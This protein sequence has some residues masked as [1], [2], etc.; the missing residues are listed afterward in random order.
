MKPFFTSI[1]RTLTLSIMGMATS[2]PLLAVPLNNPALPS[3]ARAAILA[4]TLE[5]FRG[6]DLV[7]KDGPMAKVGPDLILTFHEHRDFLARGGLARFKQRFKPSNPLIRTRDDT[8]VVDIVASGNV[9]TLKVELQALGMQDAA[10][11]GRYISGR[12]PIDQLDKVAALSTLRFA[13]P[14]YAMTRAGSVTSQGNAAM[15]AGVARSLYGFDG[16]GVTVGTLS[17]SYNCKGGAAADVASGDLPTGIAV[18]QELTPCTSGTDEGRAMMQIVHDVAPGASQKFHSAFN[19]TAAFA[20]GIIDLATAGADVINDDVI[21]FAEPMFQDGPIAQAVDTVKG[22]GVAYFSSA[23]NNAKHSYEATYNNSGQT[24]FRSGSVRH[25]FNTTS[26]TDALQSITIPDT[27]TVTLVLQW[28]DPFFSVSGGPG[29]ATDM[30]LILYSSSGTAIQGGIVNNIGGDPIEILQ[31]TNTSGAAQTY[32]I[33][34]EHVAG[35]FPGI[36]KYVYFGNMTI[37]E[38]ATNSGSSYG[39]PIAAGARA[40]G[41]ARYSKTPEFGQT[42]P[43]LEGFS[44]SGGITILFD[45]SGNPVNEQRLKPEIVAPDGGDNTFFGS[46][47]EGNGS[48]NFFGTS[49]AAPHAAGVAAL[50]KGLDPAL[51]PDALYNALQNTAIDMKAAGPDFDSGYGLIQADLA[52]ASLVPDDDLDGIANNSDNCPTVANPLQENNDLDAQ[53]DACDL[54]DDNDGLTDTDEAFYN[55]DPFVADTDGDNLTDGAEVHMYLTDPLL[56]DTDGDGLNDDTEVLTY[57]TDP[58]SSNSGDVAPLN[59]P[60]G[61]LNAG[62]LV[63]LTRIVTGVITANAPE[64]V[65][66]DLNNDGLINAADLLLLQQLILAGP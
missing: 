36:I 45:S 24:G 64:D 14:A 34:I 65:L 43:L 46:D 18:L 22:M 28:Q 33:G 61:L 42:P 53:G 35:P 27:A 55:T 50:L 54:D 4:H 52:L 29:A 11:F 41:A 12:L 5:D 19:G 6:K 9:N 30:D 62:D 16:T 26:A 17:D 57:A 31:Y 56:V 48:P 23:G 59:S 2:G 37:N 47:F 39:H 40:V 66:G 21:Y 60:D 3:Q 49:A 32:Q 13:R 7:G 8:V 10:V 63:V 1:A 51:T 38:Y 44:S 15:R 25:D 58:N 20:Q